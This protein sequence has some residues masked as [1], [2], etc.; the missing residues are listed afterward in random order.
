MGRIDESKLKEQIK[1]EA[2][3]KAYFIYGDESYLKEFYVDRLVKKLVS[4]P[5]EVFNL[6]RYD[7]KQETLDNI[8]KDA[9]LLPMMGGCNLILSRDY[10]FDKSEKDCKEIKEYL[11]DIPDTTVLIFWYDS[12]A[13][14]IKKSGRWKGIEAAFAKYGDSVELGQKSEAELVKMLISGCKK[15]GAQLDRNNARYLL[16]VSGSDIK[17]LLNEVQKLSAYACGGEITKKIIDDLAVRSLQ[18][19]VYDLSNA[20]VR[21]NY[22]KA[23]TVL[24]SLF[25]A[26]E[27]PVKVLSAISGCF[28]DM[29]RVKCAKIDGKPYEDVADYY[30]YSG[31][32][33]A[34]KNA[35]R[36]CASL[37]FNQLRKSIDIIM[38]A[39]N[40]L[41]STSANSRLILE[42][43]LVK[44]DLVSKEV[45]YD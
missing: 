40:A 6:H 34:L 20:V 45:P 5:L 29:Y 4:G 31:R 32:A 42:E 9:D 30:N 12:V 36:D 16:S 27:D 44:L 1:S 43:M 22:D 11:K 17:T 25:A 39:D 14:D 8:L 28:V 26:K 15:R 10:P 38:A 37:S 24:D 19:R 21:G 2:F 23:Y 7:G 13:P 18:A 3:S 35:A 33:F 41:K